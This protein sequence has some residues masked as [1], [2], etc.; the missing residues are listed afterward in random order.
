MTD[1]I[2]YELL[3]RAILNGANL[4]REKKEDLNRINVFPVVDN[5]TGSNLAHT[6]GYILKNAKPRGNVRETLRE[7][8]RS[9]LIGARG[10]SGAIF[11]QYFNGFY[12]GSEEKTEVTPSDLAK[13]FHEAYNKSYKALEEPVEGTVI[14][15]MRA[16]AVSFK[17]SLEQRK[18][19]KELFEIALMNTKRAL[20]DTTKTLKVLSPLGI[21]DAGA[22]GYYYFM[23]GFVQ[24]ML[25][26]TVY[27]HPEPQAE[28]S[29]LV[30]NDIH[31]YGEH[32]D[33]PYR[34][35]TEVLFESDQLDPD[36]FRDELKPLG[37]CLLLS[38]GDNLARVHLH[39]NEPWEI[40]KRTARLGKVLEHKAEDM[41]WQNT[42]AGP[43]KPGTA[44]VTDSIADLPPSFIHE[45]H[46]FQIPINIMI[47]GV[48]YEDKV[49][50]DSDFLNDHLDT[51]SSAQLNTEQ[52]KQFLTPILAQ[53]E[54]V[55]IL[56]VSSLMSGTFSRFKEALD[57]LDPERKKTALIDTKV[58][59]GAEGLLVK[60]AVHRIEAGTPFQTIVSEIETLRGRTGILVS[61]PDLGPMVRSG[62]ISEKVGDILIRLGF[63][64]L[65]SITREGKGTIKGVAFSMEKNRKILL[66]SLRGK[67]L[68]SYCIVH[69]DAIDRAESFRKDLVSM[70]GMEPLYMTQISSVV[71][72]FAGKGSI[73]VA[74]IEKD[75]TENAS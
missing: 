34:Y 52:A 48:S 1:A 69:S 16:W 8:A 19:V 22:L 35:C 44:L 13:Y 17:E 72:L 59:S 31:V 20:D 73:A 55:L 41:V 57:E 4:T 40:I 3:Y 29:A 14:T 9:A 68:E 2:H 63:R 46:I 70:T 6:M 71:T 26:N 62:R 67:K 49:T 66:K 28:I 50:V 18:T 32:A 36:R 43:A 7:I 12:M 37:D 60:E 56:T 42:L 27:I 10:N 61:V 54:K 23:D 75:V 21:V 15:L 5:D 25:G 38:T 47:D 51:A 74:Y 24:I 53:Y 64:P 58:N 45:H 11:S 65:V 33:F 30:D 39:T